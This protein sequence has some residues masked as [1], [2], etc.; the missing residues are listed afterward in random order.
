MGFPERQAWHSLL[1]GQM[2]GVLMLEH[3]T[4]VV[5][6]SKSRSGVL[7]VVA[8]GAEQ[9]GAPQLIGVRDPVLSVMQ[10]WCL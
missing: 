9:K 3:L 1:S 5:G 2:Q 6:P 7:R 4:A 8:T 10:M